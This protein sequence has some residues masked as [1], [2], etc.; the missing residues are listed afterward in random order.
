MFRTER[1]L[2]IYQ[3]GIPILLLHARTHGQLG[4][5]LGLGRCRNSLCSFTLDPCIWMNS[6]I[7]P[8][9]EVRNVI[10]KTSSFVAKNGPAFEERIYDK[11]KYN[12]KFSFLN[13]NDPYHGYYQMKVEDFKNGTDLISQHLAAA[14]CTGKLE[15]QQ[16]ANQPLNLLFFCQFIALASLKFYTLH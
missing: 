9:P 15:D 7:V 6:L 10:D 1:Q 13:T 12:P 2:N 16:E 5:R 8:P 4:L 3:L 14:S 11:E